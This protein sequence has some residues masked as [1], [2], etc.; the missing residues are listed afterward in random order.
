MA[1]NE[2]TAFTL[3]RGLFEFKTMHF[4]LCNAPATFERL[5]G[6]VLAGL[7]WQIYLIYLDD[8]I[9]H[10]ESFEAKLTNLDSVLCKLQKAG[11][12]LKP[13]KCQLFKKEVEYFGHIVSASGIK[14]DPKKI[15]AERDWPE[16]SNVIELR[17]FIGV[18]SY[19]R[20][21]IL[22]FADIAK[23]LHRLTSKEEPFARTNEYSQTSELLM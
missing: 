6:T 10:G 13:G 3:R 15:P 22:E 20:K 11:V 4:G 23:P 1:E 12:K 17:S 14:T 2:K 7:N 16:P 19:Y 18:C 5:M 8:I 9:V 21:F